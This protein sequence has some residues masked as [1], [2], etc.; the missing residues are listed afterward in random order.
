MDIR[1]LRYF[2]GI[3]ECGSLMKASERLNVAQPTLSVHVTNLEVELGVKLME[4][5][6]RGV[7]LTIEGQALY[8]RATLLLR[9]YQDM[10]GSLKD[11]RKRP[12]GWVSIG[13]PTTSGPM[14]AAELYRAVRDRLPDVK[15]YVVEGS[16]ALIY[17]LLQAGRLDFAILFNLSSDA[18][19]VS[20]P[21]T[22]EE[23]CLASRPDRT[24]AA[25]T[26]AFERILDRPMVVPCEATTWRK[27]LDDVAQRQGRIFDAHVETESLAIMKAIV[28]AGEASAILPASSIRSEVEQGLIKA[29][30][31]VNPEMRGLLALTHLPT[32]DMTLARKAVRDLV[33]ETVNAASAEPDETVASANVT[34]IL[35][36]VPSRILPGAPGGR[37]STRK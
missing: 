27:A 24:D 8:E 36:T 26:I 21:L 17:E 28:L 31:I 7:A 4:R 18:N 15:L 33:I 2:V 30:R 23:F 22:V 29:Q 35:R 13:M 34:P 19:V 14:L 9:Q 10:L 32:L 11:M 5:T 16:T 1:H 12:S 25:E 6:N 20:T 37:R 3:A